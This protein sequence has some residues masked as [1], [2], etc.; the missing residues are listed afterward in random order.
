MCARRFISLSL[1]LCLVILCK[2][3]KKKN[4]TSGA[5]ALSSSHFCVF[6]PQGEGRQSIAVSTRL[7]QTSD[8]CSLLVCKPPSSNPPTPLPARPGPRCEFLGHPGKWS[9]RSPHEATLVQNCTRMADA[10]GKEAFG[11][12]RFLCISKDFRKSFQ[13]HV[14]A[15]VGGGILDYDS[16]L[17]PRSP[18]NLQR[19]QS[20]LWA[21]FW[22]W[23]VMVM[24]A[25]SLAPS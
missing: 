19:R 13:L 3:N 9:R 21:L 12:D 17:H 8:Q 7:V 2:A 24:W 18:R 10:D 1:F 25:T 4:L 23:W 15:H 22:W 5:A 11:T 14:R 16:R 6:I 20:S